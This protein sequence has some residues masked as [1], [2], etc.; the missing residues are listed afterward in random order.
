MS[1]TS[2][3]LTGFDGGKSKKIADKNIHINSH[4]YGIVESLHHTIMNII[5]QYIKNK[6]LSSKEI[7]KIKF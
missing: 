3:S 7:K 1:I 2:I 6:Y 4:N 5:S